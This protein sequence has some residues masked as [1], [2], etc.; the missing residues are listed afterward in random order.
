MR[1]VSNGELSHPLLTSLGQTKRSRSRLLCYYTETGTPGYLAV[2]LTV[3]V[4]VLG[5]CG[6]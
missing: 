1:V 3:L 6:C 4:N 5:D 2:D